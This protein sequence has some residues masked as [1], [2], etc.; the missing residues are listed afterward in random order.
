MREASLCSSAT[1]ALRCYVA[2]TVDHLMKAELGIA[3]KEV[4]HCTHKRI[5]STLWMK[6]L[7][8]TYMWAT[9]SNYSTTLMVNSTVTLCNNIILIPLVQSTTVSTSCYIKNSYCRHM[10]RRGT[11]LQLVHTQHTHTQPGGHV[12]RCVH[13]LHWLC[14]NMLNR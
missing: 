12:Y 14:R 9:T 6:G 3:G 8:S 13:C 2:G 7:G 1:Y 4:A 10:Q 11:L 5:S